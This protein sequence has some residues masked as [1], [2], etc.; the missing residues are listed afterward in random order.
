ML[1]TI[2]GE[3]GSRQDDSQRQTGKVVGRV[4]ASEELDRGD[5][6]LEMDEFMTELD[7][8]M[9]GMPSTIYYFQQQLREAK[10]TIAKLE[11]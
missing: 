5:E 7:V 2:S 1:A 6:E 10:E 8:G 4:F 9:E 11:T 3:Y